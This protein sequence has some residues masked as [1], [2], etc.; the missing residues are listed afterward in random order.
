MSIL[1]DL[2]T[3]IEDLHEEGYVHRD[4]K[5]ENIFVQ[6]GGKVVLADFGISKDLAGSAGIIL[7]G[8]FS[9]S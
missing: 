7:P 4:I 3:A 1:V 5:P 6:D 2:A 9:L 8:T